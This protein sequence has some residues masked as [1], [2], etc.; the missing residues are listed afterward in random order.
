MYK[1]IVHIQKRY[2]LQTDNYLFLYEFFDNTLREFNASPVPLATH[3]TA[4]SE[5]YTSIP[6]LFEINLSN[7]H[8]KEPPP[9][10]RIPLSL[11]SEDN[12][13]GVF[14]NTT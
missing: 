3:E 14:S 9:V 8:S 6:V 13:G 12:S 4:S 10:I 7:H 11:I 1:N 5:T 2:A